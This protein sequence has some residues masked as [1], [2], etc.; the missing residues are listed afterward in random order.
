MSGVG[1]QKESGVGGGAKKRVVD[2]SSNELSADTG[3]KR[4][5]TSKKARGVAMSKKGS[6]FSSSATTRVGKD[7][8]GKEQRKLERHLGY[9]YSSLSEDS[10]P[11]ATVYESAEEEIKH[12]WQDLL[13]I[14]DEKDKKNRSLE[15]EISKSKMTNQH[16]KRKV[17]EEYQWTGEETNFTK[18]INHFCKYFLFPRYKFLKDGW[19]DV[20]PERL[21]SLYSLCM[22]RLKIPEGADKRDI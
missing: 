15:L 14:I 2:L 3:N 5:I 22:Q 1:G 9:D 10:M 16:N 21:R 11:E 13:K 17:R 12:S 8:V 4:G 19:Q 20:L 18:T 7:K 6:S